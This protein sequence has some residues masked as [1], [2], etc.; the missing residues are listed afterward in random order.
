MQ[1]SGGPF[2][3]AKDGVRAN[4]AKERDGGTKPSYKLGG[5]AMIFAIIGQPISC[6]LKFQHEG[7]N[8]AYILLAR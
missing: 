3:L 5:V 6:S 2:D 4:K 7:Q 8:E 1:L